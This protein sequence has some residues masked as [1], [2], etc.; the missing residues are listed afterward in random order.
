MTLE[1]KDSRESKIY[2]QNRLYGIADIYWAIITITGIAMAVVFGLSLL[3]EN[4]VDLIVSVILLILFFIRVM[5]YQ[6]RKLNWKLF[7][8]HLIALNFAIIILTKVSNI[9]DL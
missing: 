3:N 6:I 7:G 9:I 2:Y 1:P 4:I 8:I 5:M